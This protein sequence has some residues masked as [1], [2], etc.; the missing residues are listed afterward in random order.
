[1]AKVT[2]KFLNQFFFDNYKCQYVPIEGRTK[3]PSVNGDSPHT[4]RV[5]RTSSKI[6]KLL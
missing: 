6:F 5:F 3:S 2:E 1:M 4:T